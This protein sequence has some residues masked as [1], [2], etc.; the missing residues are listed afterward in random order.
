M[1]QAD[2]ESF[3][4][5]EIVR[6]EMQRAAYRQQFGDEEGAG[7][8]A[9]SGMGGEEDA[10]WEG[11]DG[12]PANETALLAELEYSQS[13]KS[14]KIPSWLKLPRNFYNWT[15]VAQNAFIK[16]AILVYV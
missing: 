13:R 7:G 2:Q 11:L 9:K 16:R 12:L 10:D 14:L 1:I 3:L 4:L 5:R 15:M 6:I 8:S